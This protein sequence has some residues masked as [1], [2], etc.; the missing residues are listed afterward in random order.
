[1]SKKSYIA[2]YLGKEKAG[3]LLPSLVDKYEAKFVVNPKEPKNW[4]LQGRK[5]LLARQETFAELRLKR[6]KE[7]SQHD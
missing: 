2:Y 5:E 4:R 6:K 7:A 3:V 1:M